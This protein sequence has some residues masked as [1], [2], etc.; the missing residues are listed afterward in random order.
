M[1]ALAEA[2]GREWVWSRPRILTRRWELKAGDDVV[3]TLDSIGWLGGGA[4]ATTSEGVWLLRHV[5]MLRGRLEVTREKSQDVIAL[6]RPAWFG[7]GT[8]EW[9]ER[10]LRWHRDDFWGRRWEFVDEHEH[11]LVAFM[12]R[13]AFVR[14]TTAVEPTEA[15]RQCPELPLLVVLGFQLLLVMQRQARAGA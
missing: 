14:S 12:R 13:P 7:A 4:R 3:A 5:G 9:G 11:T 15:G 8:L 6:F 1:R 2:W 10:R